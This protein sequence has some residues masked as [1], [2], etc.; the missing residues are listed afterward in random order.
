MFI[1][2][3]IAVTSTVAMS[4]GGLVLVAAPASAAN[5]KPVDAVY[6]A[7]AAV[8]V[9]RTGPYPTCTAGSPA[10][11]NSW[12][13]KS[14]GSPYSQTA[15]NDT[16][17]YASA[18]VDL[19]SVSYYKTIGG[20]NAL[21]TTAAELKVVANSTSTTPQKFGLEMYVAAGGPQ[22]YWDATANRWTDTSASA[23]NKPFAEAEGYVYALYSG[24]FM[25]EGYSA[26]GSAYYIGTFLM[27]GTTLPSGYTLTYLPSDT[28]GDNICDNSSGSYRTYATSA[29]MN[30]T[31]IGG[32]GTIT[33]PASG[34][35]ATPVEIDTLD[36]DGNG[37]T[38]SPTS[39]SGPRGTWSTALTAENC[40]RPGYQLT[41]FATSPTLASGSTFVRPGGPIAFNGSNRL[42]AIWTIPTT[43][44]D[45][46]TGVVVTP[47]LN[48]LTVS[49]K[50]PANDGGTRLR[51]YTVAMS[52]AGSSTSRWFFC[53]VPAERQSCK[54]PWPATNTKFVAAVA[55]V[56]DVGQSNWSAE[57]AP[58][59]PYE[60]TR[61][62]ASRNNVLLGLGGSKVEWSG[63]APGLTGASVTAQYKVGS[64]ADWTTE[65]KAAKVNAEGNYSW[66]KKFPFSANKQ[67]VTVR[68]TYGSDAATNA[69]TL[70]RGAQVGSLSAPRNV[71]VDVVPNRVKVTW[72]PPKFDGGEKITGYIMCA[73]SGSSLCRNV[74][75][76]GT[77]ILDGLDA[78]RQYTITV[79]A[80]TAKG[81]GPAA[82][83]KQQ[84]SPVEASV[85]ITRRFG[86]QLSIQAEGA[87]FTGN[88]KFR[89]EEAIAVPGET[90]SR[91][92]WNEIQS[93]TESRE[94]NRG[95]TVELDDSYT[96]ETVAVRLVTPN[97]TVYSRLSRP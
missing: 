57:S 65:A 51:G 21:T 55:A 34:A 42:Y 64:A 29:G 83:A 80:K 4:I 46:P 12:T 52:A 88:A 1:R 73:T 96:G 33:A 53:A 20:T 30:S 71:K 50:A 39:K 56:S 24:G 49:W 3:L 17:S 62:E 87:G 72:D 26:S 59:S 61:V 9:Q 22:L 35:A 86:Q 67:P 37:G 90:A 5:T 85:V 93:F 6:G 66:S 16:N 81:E 95:F 69:F 76:D 63:S 38:C 78:R 41:G 36:F 45:A 44:P 79:A 7:N 11:F 77:G 14:T 31:N 54:Q 60:F 27:N 68:F 23:V 13:V 82:K 91:W 10:T 48:A 89:L 92:R 19:S 28:T 58:A 15:F 84:V 25:H 8:D 32:S 47:E 70:T 74:G 43:K 18:R 75:T 94:F 2:R 97:G 40:S